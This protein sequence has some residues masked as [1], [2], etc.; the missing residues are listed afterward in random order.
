LQGD[1]P[2]LALPYLKPYLQSDLKRVVNYIQ[3]IDLIEELAQIDLA[4]YGI[5]KIEVEIHG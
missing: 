4:D 1:D 2:L 3:K 5:E